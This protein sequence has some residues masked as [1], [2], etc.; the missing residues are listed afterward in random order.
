MFLHSKCALAGL[1]LLIA[2]STDVVIAESISRFTLCIGEFDPNCPFAH[3][4]F[5]SCG[6]SPEELAKNIC[7]L[8]VDGQKRFSPYRLIHSGSHSGNRCGYEWFTVECHDAG[9]SSG[10]P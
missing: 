2:S 1:L 10:Q 6:A 8:T 5:G 4:A 9:P 3:D 7:S